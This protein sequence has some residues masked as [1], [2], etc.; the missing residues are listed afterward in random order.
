MSKQD[1]LKDFLTDLADTIRTKKRYPDTQKIN[2]Q[3]F[4]GEVLGIVDGRPTLFPPVITGGYNQISWVTDPRNGSFDVVTSATLDGVDITGDTLYIEAEDADKHLIVTS[5]CN[6]FESTSVDILIYHMSAQSSL[7]SISDG[8]ATSDYGLCVEVSDTDILVPQGYETNVGNK[9]FS[10]KTTTDGNGDASESLTFSVAALSDQRPST[11]KLSVVDED[12]DIIRGSVSWTITKN[13]TTVY[14]GTSDSAELS[15]P[16]EVTWEQGDDLEFIVN[17]TV[18]AIGAFNDTDWATIRQVFRSGQAATYWNAGDLK[19]IIAKDGTTYTIRITDLQA[20]RYT[21][22]DGT[23]SSYGAFEFVELVKVGSI[24]RFRMNAS[25]TNEGGWADSDV[26]GTNIPNIEA[27]RPDDM[28]AAISEVNVL[29][30]TGRGTTS[31]TSSSVNKLFLPA[32]MEMF[33]SKTYSIGNTECPLGQFDYYKAHNTDADRVKKDVG[34]TTAY[35]YWLRSPYSGS[36]TS[37]CVVSAEGS[38][39]YRGSDTGLCGVSPC[40]AI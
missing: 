30:G 20:G 3:D 10:Y 14:T 4:S 9:Y 1:N 24:T 31:G 37:F 23:G 32:E 29:S 33:S 22:A 27:L 2:P 35:R 13:G 39:Y 5:R 19:T 16:A 17:A 15:I 6:N 34:T 25:S 12:D 36:S 40:F 21:L 28:L 26:R 8:K 11:F 7:I 38:A 18:V